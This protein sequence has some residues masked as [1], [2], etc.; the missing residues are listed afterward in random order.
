M[1]SHLKA[2]SGMEVFHL[3]R[4]LQK[5]ILFQASAILYLNRYSISLDVFLKPA[6]ICFIH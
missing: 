3:E 6:F 4:W 1:G 5:C 2:G